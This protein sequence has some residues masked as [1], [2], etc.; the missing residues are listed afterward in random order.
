MRPGVVRGFYLL[1]GVLALLLGVLGVVLPL[2][3]T[4]PFVILAAFCFSRSS[5]RLHQWLLNQRL[6]GPLIRDWEA[7]G[8]IP[9]RVKWLSTSMMLVLV[10]YPILFR[11]FDWRLKALAGVSIL[12]ALLYIWSRPSVPATVTPSQGT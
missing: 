11:D 3:P 2:L 8:V 4:T 5:E 9:L 1:A 12:F 6:F 7:H 10:S